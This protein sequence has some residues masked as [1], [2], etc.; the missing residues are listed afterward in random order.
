M[1]WSKHTTDGNTEI[2]KLST[3]MRIYLGVGMLTFWVVLY[4]VFKAFGSEYI[5][6]DNGITI[7]GMVGIILSMLR[8]REY[9]IFSIISN[10]LSIVTFLMMLE[11]NPAQIIWIIQSI[12]GIICTFIAQYNIRKKDSK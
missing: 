2:K 8:F 1:N 7:F 12:Q 4:I 5:L 9:T 10:L 3:K 11:E 6:I